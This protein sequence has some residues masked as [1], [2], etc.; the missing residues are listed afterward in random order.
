MKRDEETPKRRTTLHIK[1]RVECEVWKGV[2]SEV[3]AR[4]MCVECEVRASVCGM[5]MCVALN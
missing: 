3:R 4:L 1:T 5:S 2:E